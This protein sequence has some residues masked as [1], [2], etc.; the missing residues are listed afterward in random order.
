MN[1]KLKRLGLGLVGVAAVSVLVAANAWA[2]ASG[3]FASHGTTHHFIVKGTVINSGSHSWSLQR[4]VG[5]QASGSAIVCEDIHYFG[6]R[7]DWFVTIIPWIPIKPTYTSCSTGGEPSNI[8]ID[9]PTACGENILELASGGSGTVH[10]NCTITV[11]HPNCEIKLPPQTLSGVTYT[12]TTRNG[13]AAITADTNLQAVTGHFENG[14]CVFLGT[15]HT[16]H[17]KGSLSLWGED[18]GGNPV[19]LTHTP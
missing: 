1:I 7:S 3:H 10:H 16:F 15:K 19:G 14:I 9:V 2:T 18:T 12:A 17:M 4:T 11:T 8:T 13:S 6:T 5:G